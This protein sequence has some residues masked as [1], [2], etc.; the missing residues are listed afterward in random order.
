M[1]LRQPVGGNL[2]AATCRRQPAGG[3]LLLGFN[4]V[5]GWGGSDSVGN[6]VDI[7]WARF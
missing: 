5:E 1:E 3:D 4:E 7:I 2:S 6:V